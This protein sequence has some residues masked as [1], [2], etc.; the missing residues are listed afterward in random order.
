M[1]STP[2]ITTSL[3]IGGDITVAGQWT[4]TN[5]GSSQVFLQVA[6]DGGTL[7]VPAVAAST[8]PDFNYGLPLTAAAAPGTT[9]TGTIT[10]R[11]CSDVQCT[12]PY[13]NASQTLAYTVTI[14]P[15]LDWETMQGNAAHTGYVPVTLD[16]SRFAKAW[17]WQRPGVTASGATGS[18][19]PVV[20]SAGLVYVTANGIGSSAPALFAINEAD[21]LV[22]W[23]RPF[24]LGSV[25]ASMN[26]PAVSQGTVYVP[27]TGHA[28]TFLWSF[29]ATDGTPRT[30]SSFLAQWSQILA[31]TVK[32]GVAYVNSGY[33][34]G[35]V[36]AFEGT[37]GLKKWEASAGTDGMNTPSLDDAN[38]LYSH[39]GDT[40]AILDAQSGKLLGSIGADPRGSTFDYEG[41]PLVGAENSV[42]ALIGKPW[43][44]PDV[45]K[46][47]NY[48]TGAGSVRWTSTKT[49]RRYPAVA[50]GVIYATSNTP[51][52]FDAID[53]KTGQ[54]L[55]SWS[56][57]STDSAFIHNVVVT[58]N[59]AFVSTTRAIYA[60]DLVQQ[61]P[62][63]Q[64]ITPGHVVISG[65]R[66][67]LV[68][69]GVL[70]DFG[71]PLGGSDGRL[72]AYRTR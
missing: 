41:A 27:T 43:D 57:G 33:Y 49:Y 47:Q 63:W 11:A 42:T 34:T 10:V 19:F 39:N 36:Y 25:A 12:K 23:V 2:P 40:L 6:D 38:R 20:T 60:I 22:K 72:L 24:T 48:D 53:E 1:V 3:A 70:D 54:V 55:W 8:T 35:V 64:A 30:K 16:A 45:R 56:P 9:R 71:W 59:L 26:P 52:S 5:L 44:D 58:D 14:T 7:V 4:A 69:T 15:A 46:L 65:G 61:K 67:I 68:M 17:E 31:P 28:D 62:V 37:S 18:I 29:D 50:K 13:A 51:K 66:T 21:G 32:G